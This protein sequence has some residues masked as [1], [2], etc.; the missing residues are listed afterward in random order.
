MSVRS[1][2]FGHLM[3]EVIRK[4]TCVGCGSCAAVCPI[5]SIELEA[6]TPKLVGICIACGMCYAS[7]PSAGFDEGEMDKLVFGRPRADDEVDI[8]VKKVIYAVRAKDAAILELCQD[9]GAVSAILSQF[10]NE[11]GDGAVVTGLEKNE[12][13]VPK[14]VVASNKKEVVE[15]AG[16]KYTPSPTMVGVSSAVNEHAK[17]RIAV[18]GTPC[19]IRGLSKVTVG[20]FAE[21]KIKEALS[22]KVGLFCMETYNHASFMGF[23]RSE[24]VDVSKV[25]KFQIKSGK[26]FALQE[27]RVVYEAKLS[28]VKEYVRPCCQG[29]EDFAS[30]Y[31][32]ISV[33][34]IG[35]PDGWSTVIVRTQRGE[36]A[37]MAAEKVGL[38]EIKPVEEGKAGMGFILRLAGLKKKKT[39]K[40]AE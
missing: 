13:W 14:P 16:T 20:Q 7:C 35:T 33:G 2:V 15:C 34:N 31:A 19:Q 32:D 37:L 11:G 5:E 21:G 26:L 28:K 12:I 17:K 23:L 40:E 6:G 39:E 36:D 27:G 3:T 22:L 10:L 30:E 1:K 8:G 29:C 25:D 38:V 24:G 4:G 18:V 9:G